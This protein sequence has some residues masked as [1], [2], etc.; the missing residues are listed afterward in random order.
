MVSF[1]LVIEAI[2]DERKSLA[3]DIARLERD[4]IERKQSLEHLVTSLAKRRQDD[5]IWME[6]GE[7]LIKI[8][9]RRFKAL[10][11][12]QAAPKEPEPLDSVE[13]DAI[14]V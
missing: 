12:P 10:R 3:R 9:D 14:K 6:A 13:K 5:A 1:K 11:D 4:L 2:N 7:I 8:E